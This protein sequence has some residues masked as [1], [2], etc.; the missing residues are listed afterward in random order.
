MRHVAVAMLM[1]ASCGAPRPEPLPVGA[2]GGAGIA[3][4]AE[5]IS[6]G[7]LEAHM[8]ARMVN[9]IFP[10][11]RDAVRVML[12]DGRQVIAAASPREAQ[13]AMVVRA[14]RPGCR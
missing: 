2:F 3:T 4:E 9:R 13:A 12:C 8:D 5:A 11:G 7:E 14:Y 6:L 10:H 1:L